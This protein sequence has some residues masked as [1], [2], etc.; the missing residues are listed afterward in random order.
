MQRTSLSL[1]SNLTA[2]TFDIKIEF[3]ACNS[4]CSINMILDQ[5]GRNNNKLNKLLNKAQ[6]AGFSQHPKSNSTLKLS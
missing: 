3:S 2:W 6:L 5:E 4:G 1:K